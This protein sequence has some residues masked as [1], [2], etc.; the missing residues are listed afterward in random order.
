MST[1]VRLV[2]V[3]STIVDEVH[4]LSDWQFFMTLVD[5]PESTLYDHSEGTT[6]ADPTEMFEDIAGR[7]DVTFE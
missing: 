7:A 2:K 5:D 3:N 1:A 4:G 6:Y